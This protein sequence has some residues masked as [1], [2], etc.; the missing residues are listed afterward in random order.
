[1][2]SLIIAGLEELVGH[3]EEF[4]RF[5]PAFLGLV[6]FW[7]QSNVVRWGKDLI[8]PVKHDS[9]RSSATQYI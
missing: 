5:F 9:K 2:G 4:A 1:V 3:F 6:E 7:H 8:A